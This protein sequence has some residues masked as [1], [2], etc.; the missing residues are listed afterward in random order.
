MR[1]TLQFLIV[2]LIV[3]TLLAAC[4]SSKETSGES[5]GK[6]AVEL[7]VVSHKPELNSVWPKILEQF[8]KEYPNIKVTVNNPP[9]TATVLQTRAVANDMPD[10]ATFPYNTA[11]LGLVYEGYFI[12]LTKEEFL[13]SNFSQ[14]VVDDNKIDG[15][16]YF[17]PYL[18]NG[19]GIYYNVDLFNEHDIEI[20]KTQD[21]LFEVL[22]YFKSKG[23]MGLSFSDQ[24]LWTI[25]ALGDRLTGLFFDDKG[26]L[27]KDIAEGK[28]SAADH[29]GMKEVAEFILKLH[30]YGQKD[31]LGVGYEQAINEFANGKAAMMYQGTFALPLIKE[32]NPD[33]NISMF[34]VP[35]KTE[36]ETKVGTNMDYGLAISKDSEYKKEAKIFLEWLTKK[37]TAQKFHD[38]EGSPSLVNGVESSVPELEAVTN[39]I[40]EGKNFKIPRNYWAPGMVT[41]FNKVLQDLI[42]TGDVDASMKKLDKAV[43]QIYNK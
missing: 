9:E 22:D 32:A 12:D 35:G 29:Q 26:E 2:L 3:G 19:T 38:I 14:D 27:F 7:E 39:A 28:A 42:A 13:K 37:E 17:V 30:K 1:K 25:G 11:E 36:A 23:I 43:K 34:L 16:N 4:S 18:A 5:S 31:S 33:L 10:I 40:K 20:P 24:E 8:H 15:V 6:G 41:E 21:E